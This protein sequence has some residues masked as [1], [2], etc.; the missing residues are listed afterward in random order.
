MVVGLCDSDVA[1]APRWPPFGVKVGRLRW[2]RTPALL[3]QRMGL[4]HGAGVF[5]AATSLFASLLSER[6]L[7]ASKRFARRGTVVMVLCSSRHRGPGLLVVSGPA[8]HA[9]YFERGAWANN[10]QINGARPGLDY[11][12]RD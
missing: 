10:G 9:R 4:P 2:R 5:R 1:G 6:A 11:L 7:T 12:H 8:S 3:V